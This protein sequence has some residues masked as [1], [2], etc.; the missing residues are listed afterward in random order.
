M[1]IRV[2]LEEE[3]EK[4]SEQKS[5]GVELHARRGDAFNVESARQIGEGDELLIEMPSNG[6][7]MLKG[8][9]KEPNIVYNRETMANEIKNPDSSPT[10]FLDEGSRIKPRQPEP[11]VMQP[12]GSQP[13]DAN[14]P[15]SQSVGLGEGRAIPGSSD[16][17]NVDGQTSATNQSSHI[18]VDRGA[19]GNEPKPPSQPEIK[20]PEKK[21]PEK[22]APSSSAENPTPPAPTSPNQGRTIRG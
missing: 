10:R 6:Q 13:V 15:G 16:A 14:P 18:P 21:E 19:P 22:D 3:N 8:P 17:Q 1:R 2:K 9:V 11:D 5:L 7:I 12:V 20:E 4:P